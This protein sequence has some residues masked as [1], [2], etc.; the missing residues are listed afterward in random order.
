[1]QLVLPLTRSQQSTSPAMTMEW[2]FILV[3]TTVQKPSRGFTVP[4]LSEMLDLEPETELGFWSA[5]EPGSSEGRKRRSRL[6]SSP[7]SLRV[8]H[9]Y[10]FSHDLTYIIVCGQDR[11]KDCCASLPF[12]GDS[13]SALSLRYK[14]AQ[15]SSYKKCRFTAF[16]CC[17]RTA[18]VLTHTKLLPF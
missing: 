9:W 8:S 4:L 18:A 3:L 16:L 7:G 14:Q 2:V 17:L 6:A 13:V 5:L 15:K 10:F 1:M 11:S 12:A